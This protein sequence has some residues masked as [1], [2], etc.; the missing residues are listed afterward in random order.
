MHVMLGGLQLTFVNTFIYTFNAPAGHGFKYEFI[1]NVT[2][3]RINSTIMR[4]GNAAQFTLQLVD[5]YIYSK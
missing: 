2:A 1:Y 5:V 3:F 4:D